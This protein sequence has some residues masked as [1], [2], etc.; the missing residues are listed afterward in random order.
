MSKDVLIVQLKLLVYIA[1]PF[2]QIA[3]WDT[4]I[5]WSKVFL[6]HIKKVIYGFRT[7]SIKK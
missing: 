2:S 1:I 3:E 4:V 5:E 7:I 6:L